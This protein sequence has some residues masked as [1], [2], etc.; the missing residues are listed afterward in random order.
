MIRF[1]Y[2]HKDIKDEEKERVRHEA[3][4][5]PYTRRFVSTSD[6]L[7]YFKKI[8]LC[9]YML[10]HTGAG[11]SSTPTPNYSVFMDELPALTRRNRHIHTYAI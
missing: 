5:H 10:P 3:R 11:T 1:G 7:M 6:N 9:P 8:S 4:L 2:F